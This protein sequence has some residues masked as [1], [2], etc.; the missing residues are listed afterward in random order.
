MEE[1]GDENEGSMDFGQFMQSIENNMRHMMKE[2]S[3]APE[4][5]M[6]HWNAF[7]SAI[8]WSERWIQGLLGF[9]V[10][11]FLLVILT[12]KNADAQTIIFLF[13]CVMTFMAERINNYCAANWSSFATQNY[14]D[15]HGTFA[16]M[17]YSGPLL[18][19]ALFQLVCKRDTYN[20]LLLSSYINTS[21]FCYL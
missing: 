7:R 12:R 11:L 1:E 20:H 5:A 9:H 10:I 6:D 18:L 4:T 21:I 16:G 3:K 14:F 15:A 19:I 2:S 13:V 17:L 8:D